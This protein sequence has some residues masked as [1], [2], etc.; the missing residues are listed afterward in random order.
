MHQFISYGMANRQHSNDV[1]RVLTVIEDLHVSEQYSG[2]FAY[3]II[4]NNTKIQLFVE[5]FLAE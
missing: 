3:K 5:I 4:I 1:N 2:H